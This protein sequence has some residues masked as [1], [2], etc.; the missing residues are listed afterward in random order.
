MPDL[1]S[2]VPLIDCDSR[3]AGRTGVW[4]T[5]VPQMWRAEAPRV[6]SNEAS[7]EG[8]WHRQAVRVDLAWTSR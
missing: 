3:V 8:S 6:A 2:D 4:S 1:W 7:R 5:C